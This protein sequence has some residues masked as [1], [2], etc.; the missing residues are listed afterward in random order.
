MTPYKAA[1]KRVYEI[2]EKAQKGDI[3]SKVFDIFIFVLIILSIVSTMLETVPEL[4]EGF[5]NL[6]RYFEI[7]SI[8]IFT[9]EYLL[10]LWSSA[11]NPKY[12]RTFVGRIKYIF[13]FMA[14]VDLLAI[15]PF[16]MPFIFPIDMRFL[17]AL[18]LLRILRILKI[19]RYAAALDSMKKV[20]NKR[21]E[22]L[23]ITI[24]SVGILLIISSSIMYYVETEAQPDSFT[25]I[26]QAFW[27]GIVTLTTVGYG[28][29]Y[30]ITAVGKFLSSIVSFLGIGLVAIPTG[31]LGSAFLEEI[32]NKKE[33]SIE[34]VEFSE[35]IVFCG[36]SS[37]ALSVF[38]ELKSRNYQDKPMVLISQTPN[39]NIPGV[40]YINGDFADEA[41]LKKAGIDR[42]STCV[43]FATSGPNDTEQKIDLRSILTVYQIRR[44]NP[45]TH[46]IVEI[47]R[48]E[49]AEIIKERMQGDEIIFKEDIDTAVTASAIRHPFIS[50]FLYELLDGKGKVIKDITV[51]KAGLG[52]S[53]PVLFEKVLRYGIEKNITVLGF[54][55][56]KDE[57]AYLAPSR[58]T[59]MQVDDKILFLG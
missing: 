32:S 3:L 29:I 45:D 10:R 57:K 44:L 24:F 19:G 36:W 13:S 18:R 21:K 35:H 39:P 46:L 6:F 51:R 31:I 34:D 40:T 26:F 14:L 37:T 58:G 42:S 47:V 49:N 11:Q 48:K 12:A 52:K 54:I 4:K 56:L 27:W 9:I 50:R 16:Y 22:D 23:L 7:V 2:L 41:I 8:T 55:S 38:E 43:V 59:E 5:S 33:G 20:L 28:D 25:N 17:R 1:Q 53:E 30:P 15:L